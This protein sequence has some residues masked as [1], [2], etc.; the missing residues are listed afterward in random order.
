MLTQI[1]SAEAIFDGVTVREGCHFCPFNT[2]PF[3]TT[4]FHLNDTFGMNNDPPRCVIGAFFPLCL[5]TFQPNLVDPTADETCCRETAVNAAAG[6]IIIAYDTEREK[7]VVMA[8]DRAAIDFGAGVIYFYAEVDL[9]DWADAYP[10]M[11][12]SNQLSDTDCFDFPDGSGQ[13]AVGAFDGTVELTVSCEVN[14]DPAVAT[15]EPCPVWSCPTS[16]SGGPRSVTNGSN[17]PPPDPC[18]DPSN[19]QWVLY[20]YSCDGD[21]NW[22]YGA[23]APEYFCGRTPP[24]PYTTSF[25]IFYDN[26][27]GGWVAL[28]WQPAGCCGDDIPDPGPPPPGPC[29]T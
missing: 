18:P 6:E 22:V 17:G 2:S 9:C 21:G 29:P 7:L 24:G 14:D 13:I 19:N 8:R 20:S 1:C 4:C 12:I 5:Y 3:R 10:T 28:Q 26:N 16:T 23:F 27:F 11:A 15:C 25:T